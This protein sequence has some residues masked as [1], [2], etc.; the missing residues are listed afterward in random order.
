MPN[1]T[2]IKNNQITDA[3]LMANTKVVAGSIVGSLFNSN[4]TTTADFTITGNL[5]V[6]GASTTATVAATNTEINDAL[7]VLNNDA[8]GSNAVD[9]GLV[10]ERGDDTNQE[11]VWDESADEF[12]FAS[13]PEVGTTAGDTTISAY[14]GLHVGTFKS[15]DLT[16]TRVTYASTDGQ[17]VD[18]ANMTF[19]GTDLT[20]ASAIVSDLTATRVT[21][22]GTSGALEDSANMT[23][24]GTDLTVASAIVSDLTAGRVTFAGTSGA[25]EDASQLTYASSAL[26]VDQLVLDGTAA[27]VTISTVAASGEDLILS[28]DSGNVDFDGGVATNLADPTLDS[29]AV[30]LGYLNSAISSEVTNIQLDDTDITITDDGTNPG[31][32]QVNVDGTL[33]GNVTASTVTLTQDTE[34]SATTTST[35]STTGALK[36]GGGVGVAENLNVGGSATVTGAVNIDDTT[37]ST[38]TS[39]G[40]LVVDGGVGVAENITVGG[41]TKSTATTESTN[42]TSGAIIT[43]G[44]VGIAKNLNVGGNVVVTGD[45]TVQGTTTTVNSTEVTVADLNLTLADGAADSSAANG[46]GITVDGANATLVYTH[47]TTSWDLNKTT[48]VTD[49]AGATST[50]SGALQSAGGLGVAEN[51][52]I[53][54][55]LD[56]TGAATLDSTLS[57]GGEATLASAIVSDLTAGRVVLAGTSGA[58]E[59]STNLTFDGST[60]A[61]TGAATVSTTLGVTGATTLSSTLGVTG[62]TT[63]SS[64]L[65]VTGATTLSSTLDVTSATTLSST[66]DVTGATNLNDTTTSTSNTTGALIVDGG[67][68][69]A[70]NFNMGGDADIDGTITVGGA[71]TL[72]STLG[73]TG[74][75]T[76]SSTLDVTGATN[77]NDTTDS[78][79]PTTGALIVDGGVGVAKSLVTGAG[80]IINDD[81]TAGADFTVKSDNSTTMLYIDGTNDQMV[82]GGSNTS[83]TTGSVVKFNTVDSIHLPTG[84]TAQ[85]PT[86]VAGMIRFNNS[87]SNLEFYNGSSWQSAQ[88]SFTVIASETFDGDDSTTAF[89]L[90]DSQTTASCIVSV[91]GIVQQPTESYAVSGTTLTFTEAPETGDKIEVRKL[92]TTT[93]VSSLSDGATEFSTS[94]DNGAKII[95]DET[96]VTVGTSATTIDSFATTAYRSAEY[97]VQGQNAA[98]D[99]WEVAKILLVHDG[100]T[101]TIVVYGVTDTGSDDWTYSAT[102]SGGDVLL[103]ATAGEA[104]TTVKVFPTYI[105]A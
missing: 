77:L 23:F 51:A 43:A 32:I 13:T 41:Q 101:A 92:T 34:V 11:L 71:A 100:S 95:H 30:T 82:I 16:S 28:A 2:R 14:A 67:F 66:L 64:T 73:V 87:T 31:Y 97:L 33:V 96:G 62:A 83:V 44:G 75:T 76:L 6:L 98:G 49:N 19:D 61:V 27:G 22:A 40:A 5:T 103:Q 36:V 7:I 80:A 35:S 3:T 59:D 21:F 102:V 89:T 24:D 56:V 99:A 68:G 94:G 17:L 26:T 18:S 39:T 47:A 85:R 70:E 88:G 8:T 58:I 45:L 37:S 60:L 78:T 46:G 29:D 15:S 57:V 63:L 38:T 48:R 42:V 69:L 25:L 54:G 65:G 20:V 53:G 81:Q 52:Y 93:T 105:V 79:S 12:V 1:L 90:S 91:N 55:I 10:F 74:A 86:G 4:I 50:S 72:S 104:G 9:V 84:T